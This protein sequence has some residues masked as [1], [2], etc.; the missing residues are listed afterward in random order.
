VN[1]RDPVLVGTVGA[2]LYVTSACTGLADPG[3]HDG[4][5]FSFDGLGV[6]GRPAF[7]FAG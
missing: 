7:R 2:T 5:L 3:P 6:R 1:V 4:C